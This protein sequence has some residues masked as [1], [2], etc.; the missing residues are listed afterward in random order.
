[1]TESAEKQE[2]QDHL[3]IKADVAYE[4]N[5]TTPCK[6]WL[7]AIKVNSDHFFYEGCNY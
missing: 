1:M 6:Y 5:L 4:K 7:K 3:T 2:F